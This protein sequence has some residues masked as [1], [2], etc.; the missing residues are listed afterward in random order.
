MPINIDGNQ[1]NN[2]SGLVWYKGF[3]Y[4]FREAYEITE[5]RN[6]GKVMIAIKGVMRKIEQKFVTRW[7]E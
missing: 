1:T 3:Q 7:P 6:K 2:K 5:G 4:P